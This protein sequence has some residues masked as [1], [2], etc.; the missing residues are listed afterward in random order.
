M[1]VILYNLQ[2]GGGSDSP[3][4][5]LVPATRKRRLQNLSAIIEALRPLRPDVLGMIEADAGSWRMAGIDMAEELARALELPYLDEDCKYPHPVNRI[6]LVSYNI[7]ALASNQP[8]VDPRSREL[9]VGFKRMVLVTETGGVTFILAHLSLMGR[10]RR[11]Q[12]AD[13]AT[14]VVETDGPVVLMGDLNALPDSPELEVLGT[15]AGLSRVPLGETFPSWNPTR[16]LDHFF[17]SSDIRVTDPAVPDIMLSDHLPIMM[18]IEP[19][20]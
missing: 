17:V 20:D 12:V 7:A 2:Y 19:E 5:Y 13:L 1:R 9:S 10:S 15:V 16:G 4:S 8:L 6:P 11:R 14:F 3:L 18:D